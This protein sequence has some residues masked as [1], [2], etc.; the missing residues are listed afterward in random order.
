[1]VLPIGELPVFWVDDPTTSGHFYP[2]VAVAGAALNIAL[3]ETPL[4]PAIVAAIAIFLLRIL[5]IHFNWG[6]PEFAIDDAED[7]S[8][9]SRWRARCS[10]DLL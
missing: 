4:S 5:S 8:G 1:M 10:C 7:G 6:A 3:L 2:S 9:T